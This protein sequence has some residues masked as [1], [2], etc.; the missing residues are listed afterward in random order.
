MKNAISISLNQ[1]LSIVQVQIR[2]LSHE[3]ILDIGLKVHAEKGTYSL[4]SPLN[5]EKAELLARTIPEIDRMLELGAEGVR[6]TE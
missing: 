4:L 2:N 5:A 1:R 3:K 6:Y